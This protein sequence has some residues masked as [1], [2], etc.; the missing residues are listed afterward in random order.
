MKQMK[1]LFVLF[2][3]C[4]LISL[5]CALPGSTPP[6]PAA[7]PTPLGDTLTFSIPA[8]THNLQPGE[9][10][11]GTRLTYVERS[12]DAYKVT[13]DGLEATKRTG[14]SFIWSGVVGPGVYADYNLRL[15][16]A[17]LGPLPVIG[18]VNVTVFYPNPL[19]I[20]PLPDL[21]TALP[22]HNLVIDYLIPVGRIVPGTSLVYQGIFTQGEG[23]QQTKLAQLSGLTGYP[24]LAVGDSLQWRGQL[25]SN[26]YIEYN[27]R[28]MSVNEDGLRVAGVANLWVQP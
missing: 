7:T 5:A 27:L 21:S 28:V 18:S 3:V 19:A 17:L 15:T 1:G 14:D 9:T 20:D 22:F 2:G 23:E 16:T 6:G 10:V 12:G 26:V 13:I 11:P 4:V 25:L 8:Y 24:Y